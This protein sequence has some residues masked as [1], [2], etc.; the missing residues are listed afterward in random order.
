MTRYRIALEV[1][2]LV[3]PQCAACGHGTAV[4]QSADVKVLVEE[5]G[6]GKGWRSCQWGK[7]AAAVVQAR[8]P[9]EVWQGRRYVRCMG[10]WRR[11]QWE[12]AL[13]AEVRNVGG[14]GA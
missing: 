12:K 7:A 8:V 14:V 6:V 4:E 2:G 9:A 5:A 13:A 11:A 1:N 10:Q 3:S